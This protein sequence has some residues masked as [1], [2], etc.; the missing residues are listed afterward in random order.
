[1]IVPLRQLDGEGQRYSR[2]PE[3]ERCLEELAGVDPQA[4]LERCRLPQSHLNHVPDE[5]VLYAVRHRREVHPNELLA[6]LLLRTRALLR[7][8]DRRTL[9]KVPGTGRTVGQVAFEAFEELLARDRQE[10]LVRLDFYEV[11]FAKAAKSLWRNTYRKAKTPE[12]KAVHVNGDDVQLTAAEELQ[13]SDET[14]FSLPDI[15]DRY[16]RLVLGKAID[17]LSER[18]RSVCTMWMEDIPIESVDPKTD[19]MESILGYTGRT[20]RSDLQ[21]IKTA[22]RSV[23]LE[24]GYEP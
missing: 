4:L 16:F 1:M 17:G 21:K 2:P 22:L 12:T 24:A 11:R 23:L 3:I 19:S 9:P 20:I 14:P 15:D 10:Y 8:R 13:I 7:S 6:I 18:Q 5:C